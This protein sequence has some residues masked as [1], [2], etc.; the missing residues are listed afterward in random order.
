MPVQEHRASLGP[1]TEL[2][3]RGLCILSDFL[4]TDYKYKNTRT[5]N[6]HRLKT[7]A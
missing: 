5:K 7:R 4:Y 1:T 6:T 3:T 2:E